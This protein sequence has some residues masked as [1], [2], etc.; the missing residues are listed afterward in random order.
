M[1]NILLMKTSDESKALE[2][3]GSCVKNPQH[4]NQLR[5]GIQARFLRNVPKPVKNWQCNTGPDLQTINGYCYELSDMIKCPTADSH[6]LPRKYRKS[7][8]E[9]YKAYRTRAWCIFKFHKPNIHRRNGL[10]DKPPRRTPRPNT[11]R[12]DPD[13]PRHPQLRPRLPGPLRLHSRPQNQIHLPHRPPFPISLQANHLHPRKPQGRQSHTPSNSN[14]APSKPSQTEILDPA[15]AMEI[16]R[17]KTDR[18]HL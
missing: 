17:I 11:L 2:Y 14:M 12:P 9:Y 8:L 16:P 5:S 10:A 13:P 3:R 1:M 15:V 4:H 18:I 6:T 7:M